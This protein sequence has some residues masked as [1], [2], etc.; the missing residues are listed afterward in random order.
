MGPQAMEGALQVAPGATLKAGYDFTIPGDNNSVF[1]TFTNPAV[2]FNVKCAN[3]LNPTTSMVTLGM[4]TQVYD[5]TNGADWYP[6]GDQSSS[7]VYQG[8]VVVP[9]VCGGGKVSFQDGGSF[10][11]AIS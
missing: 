1:V 8:S 5:S 11:A 2:T 7:L 3:G 10:T 4:P 6:S 9:D